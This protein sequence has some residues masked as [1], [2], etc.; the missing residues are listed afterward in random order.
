MAG[1]STNPTPNTQRRMTGA[2]G[3]PPTASYKVSA[4]FADGYRNTRFLTIAGA[5]AV[6]KA[7]RTGAALL[8]RMQRCSKH[9]SCR[10]SPKR[11]SRCWEARRCSARAG[12]LMPTRWC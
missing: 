5:Q 2:T 11:A 3:G 7:P 12:A 4:T 9:A 1:S 6:Q 10:R 8:T